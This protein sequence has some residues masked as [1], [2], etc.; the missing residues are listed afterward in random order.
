[1]SVPVEQLEIAIPQGY[2][3]FIKT[4][5]QASSSTEP[6]E[7]WFGGQIEYLAMSP[8]PTSLWSASASYL[9]IHGGRFFFPISYVE[10]KPVCCY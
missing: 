9:T 6:L 4:I 10:I 1:M 8:S 2:G 3:L 5:F 7:L